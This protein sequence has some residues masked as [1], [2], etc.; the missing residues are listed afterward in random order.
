MTDNLDRTLCALLP[1]RLLVPL[2][3]AAL[4]LYAITCPASHSASESRFQCGQD[5]SLAGERASLRHGRCPSQPYGQ[6]FDQR[7]EV[8]VLG[9]RAF[10]RD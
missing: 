7:G 2:V 5:F 8:K 4:W 10:V 9:L 6:P 1:P 3:S